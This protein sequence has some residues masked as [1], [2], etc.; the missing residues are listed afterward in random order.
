MVPLELLWNTKASRLYKNRINLLEYLNFIKN[1]SP[2]QCLV[3]LQQKSSEN[4]G[5]SSYK[6]I[7]GWIRITSSWFHGVCDGVFKL[8]SYPIYN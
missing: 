7:W 1:K 6:R 3:I 8:R 2:Q 5:F 4:Q